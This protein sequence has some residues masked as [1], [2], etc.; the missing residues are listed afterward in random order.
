MCRDCVRVQREQRSHS[1]AV[2]AECRWLWYW[3]CMRSRTS[4]RGIFIYSHRRNGRCTATNRMWSTESINYF[5][6]YDLQLCASAWRSEQMYI[7]EKA[8]KKRKIVKRFR[9]W[10]L[11]RHR[12]NLNFS[13]VLFRLICRRW[14][15]RATHQWV[16][17][18]DWRVLAV[19]RLHF[20]S[21]ELAIAMRRRWIR[22]ECKVMSSA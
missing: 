1:V 10:K 21:D 12:E 5:I 17:H 2:R 13:S 6:I 14:W 22:V 8:E 7:N 3:R 20:N 4:F 19:K 16:W 11:C 15:A 9:N 18:N